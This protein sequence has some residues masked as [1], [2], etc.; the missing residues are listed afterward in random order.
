MELS[1]ASIE[2]QQDFDKDLCPPVGLVFECEHGD[3]DECWPST[4][5]SPF[6]I[7]VAGLHRTT[8]K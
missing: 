4:W 2:F 6:T 3:R 8:K 7:S 1:Y 5:H